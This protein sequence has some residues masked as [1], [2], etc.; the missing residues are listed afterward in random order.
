MQVLWKD[1]LSKN[2]TG[3]Y[4][5]SISALMSGQASTF[6]YGTHPNHVGRSGTKAVIV[7]TLTTLDRQVSQNGW[8]NVYPYH[9]GQAGIYTRMWKGWYLLKLSETGR[10][11]YTGV[12][13]Y[14]KYMGQ[15]E[16]RWSEYLH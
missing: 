1:T 11:R 7:L 8:H 15:D 6:E 9:V 5:A 2:G 14:P 3:R 13:I 4:T 12:N 16:V 10:Y